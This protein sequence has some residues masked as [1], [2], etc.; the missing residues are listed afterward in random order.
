MTA[1]A[2]RLLTA[3]FIWLLMAGLF[4]P[5]LATAVGT[6]V[7]SVDGTGYDS[8]EK[9]CDAAKKNAGTVVLLRDINMDR[10]YLTISSTVTV[11]LN[12][13]SISAMSGGFVFYINSGDLT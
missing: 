7:A 6:Y 2:K 1:N 12:G 3:F 8:L 11:D 10:S 13:Y 5:E 4:Q 9:A